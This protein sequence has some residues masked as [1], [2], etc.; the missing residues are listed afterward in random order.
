MSTKVNIRP[1][2]MTHYNCDKE[3]NIFAFGLH[4]LMRLRNTIVYI[5]VLR[6]ARLNTGSELKRVDHLRGMRERHTPR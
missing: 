2:L 3:L 5:E 1:N 6:E 4:H